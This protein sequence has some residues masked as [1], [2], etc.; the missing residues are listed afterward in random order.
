MSDLRDERYSVARVA[1]DAA[2]YLAAQA[3][4]AALAPTPEPEPETPRLPRQPVGGL[5]ATFV[6]LIKDS[7][8]VKIGRASNLR[9]RFSNVRVDNSRAEMVAFYELPRMIGKHLELLLHAVFAE[10]NPN[11][12]WFDIEPERAKAALETMI[13]TIKGL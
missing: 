7:D 9:I 12:E 2:A 10:H 11:G 13:A 1:A 6:Y 3:E 8:R 5:E 4:K